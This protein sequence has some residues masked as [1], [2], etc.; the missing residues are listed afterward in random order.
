[1][2]N[3][4]AK[5]HMIQANGRADK[6]ETAHIAYLILERRDAQRDAFI[7]RHDALPVKSVS[8]SPDGKA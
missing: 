8:L 4:T 5:Y 2:N 1:M 6:V 7:I 3:V